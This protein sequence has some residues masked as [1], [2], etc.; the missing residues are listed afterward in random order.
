MKFIRCGVLLSIIFACAFNAKADITYTVNL[1]IGATGSVTGDIVTDGTTGTLAT[2]NIVDWD[3]ALKDSIGTDDLLGPLSGN[4]S[5]VDDFGSDLSA[6]LT[7]LTYNF[8][9]PSEGEFFFEGSG[10]VCFGPSGGDCAEGF[11]G[12]VEGLDVGSREQ[13]TTLTGTQVIAT[14]G[15]TSTVPEPNSVLLLA[16]ILAAALGLHARRTHKRI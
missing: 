13:N 1:S 3:L 11:V 10:F 14:V 12:N 16:T 8:S 9:D 4:N 2:S 15:G 6:T 7:R 5:I